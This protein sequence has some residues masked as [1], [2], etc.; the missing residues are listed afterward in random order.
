MQSILRTGFGVIINRAHFEKLCPKYVKNLLM[1]KGIVVVRGLDYS[2]TKLIDYCKQFG[3]L[4]NHDKT[5]N[6]GYGYQD[7][8]KLNGVKNK[9]VNGRDRL[10]LHADGGL[11]QTRVDHVF[12]YAHEIANLKFQGATVFV[13][14]RRAVEEM[15]LHL[16]RVLEEET[17]EYNVYDR[18]YYSVGSPPSWFKVPVFQDLGWTR[19]FSCYFNFPEDHPNP[20]WEARIS[21]FSKQETN[22][23][24]EELDAF[25]RDYKYSY[26][27]HWKKGDL[28]ISD[29]RNSIHGREPFD[30]EATRIIFRLQTIED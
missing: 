15:P 20:G 3:T 11:V 23:F 25:F 24:F 29:N 7:I 18:E 12:L 22:R 27:H 4:V 28:V 1:D 16:R 19:K 10:S 21:G 8:F 2:E 13:D 30:D 9:V 17:F 26:V 6:V 5:K 14:Q